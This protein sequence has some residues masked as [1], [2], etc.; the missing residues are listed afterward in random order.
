MGGEVV[1]RSDITRRGF[2]GGLVAGAAVL[3]VPSQA[4]AMVPRA[5]APYPIIYVRRREDLLRLE[6][7]LVNASLDKSNG[8]ITPSSGQ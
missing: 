5:D 2:L 7:T 8:R 4:L 1:L 6:V 3:A